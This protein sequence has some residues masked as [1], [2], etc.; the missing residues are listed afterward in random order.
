LRP[1]VFLS[2][3]AKVVPQANDLAWRA[4]CQ[5]LNIAQRQGF[6]AGRWRAKQVAVVKVHAVTVKG[7]ENRVAVVFETKPLHRSFLCSFGLPR[8]A[9]GSILHGR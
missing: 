1:A 7:A 4:G 3:C 2:G 8:H 9:D 5:P 6:A